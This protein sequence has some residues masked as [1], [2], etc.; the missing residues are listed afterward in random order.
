MAFAF[1]ASENGDINHM[2]GS[3]VAVLKEN[4]SCFMCA[5]QSVCVRGEQPTACGLHA[6]CEQFLCGPS[7]PQRKKLILMNMICTFARVVGVA[8]DKITTL[9]IHG[10]KR[11]PTTG[12]CLIFQLK[13]NL[14]ENLVCCHMETTNFLELL[15]VIQREC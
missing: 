9:F 12:L 15:E 13:A 10:G 5:Y 11:L 4:K 6:A 1:F 14:F 3:C 7:G 8:C 2:G